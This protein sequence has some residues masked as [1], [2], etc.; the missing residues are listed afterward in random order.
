MTVQY[1]VTESRL[2]DFFSKWIEEGRPNIEGVCKASSS[3]LSCPAA[4]G[5]HGDAVFAVFDE[6]DS[7]LIFLSEVIEM[8]VIAKTNLDLN[9]FAKKNRL[10]GQCFTTGC[11]H[12][13]GACRLG[14]F[15]SNVAVRPRSHHCAI[16]DSCRWLNE[17]GPKVCG[18]CA[19]LRNLPLEV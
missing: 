7:E 14:Y 18:P 17:N 12:W 1:T 3:V 10:V 16:A 19:T 15:V 13:Q 2:V 11:H 5:T 8:P 6:T 9:R 4:S